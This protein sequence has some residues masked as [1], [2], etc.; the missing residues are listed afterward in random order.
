M[1]NFVCEALMIALALKEIGKVHTS[2]VI[3][4]V[5]FVR[6]RVCNKGLLS[7][8]I[9]PVPVCFNFRQFRTIDRFEGSLTH[10]N[11]FQIL[12]AQPVKPLGVDV[13]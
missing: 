3:P 2:V 12:F 10:E 9:I 13:E 7:P 11:A 5:G 6:F 4:A 1:K 8:V